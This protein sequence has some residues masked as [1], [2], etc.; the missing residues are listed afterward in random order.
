MRYQQKHA[1]KSQDA[2]RGVEVETPGPVKSGLHFRRWEAEKR[3]QCVQEGG[4]M[5][6]SQTKIE[7]KKKLG[8][9]VDMSMGS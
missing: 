2:S 9:D 1:P 7:Q 5:G 8:F 3:T 6:E 4:R